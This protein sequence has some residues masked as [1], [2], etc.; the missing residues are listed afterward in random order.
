M[1]GKHESCLTQSQQS[2]FEKKFYKAL[3]TATKI[4]ISLKE[5]STHLSGSS[6]LIIPLLRARP[7]PGKR[8]SIRIPEPSH[9]PFR[10]GTPSRGK[11]EADLCHS[12]LEAPPTLKA[13][14]SDVESTRDHLN[15]KSNPQMLTK[16]L[17]VSNQLV[18]VNVH[19]ALTAMCMD[20]TILSRPLQ[21]A[22]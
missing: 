8:I 1:L 7:L 17:E 14:L 10:G 3:R 6:S 18:P 19:P 5:I 22:D 21:L 20:T 4:R 11:G 9:Q 12:R 2:L 15:L 13:R 16:T